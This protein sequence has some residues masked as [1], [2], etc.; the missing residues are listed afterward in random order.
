MKKLYNGKTTNRVHPS[1]SPPA[2]HGHLSSLPAAI[3][4]LAT[5]LSPEEQQVLSYL[6]GNTTT[7]NN[8]KSKQHHHR[9]IKNQQHQPE[10]TCGC[11]LCYK[12]FWSR[13]DSSP[14]RHLIHLIIDAAEQHHQQNMHEEAERTAARGR[15]RRSSSSRRAAGK[16]K[17]AELEE[18]RKEVPPVDSG[19][20][21]DGEG[22]SE[23]MEKEEGG[24]SKSSSVRRLVSFI[25]ERVWGVWN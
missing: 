16:K 17:A 13:W 9:A 3:L 5:A 24:E 4:T 20:V 25:G 10:L 12:S 14:N 11:F 8:N 15:S 19:H 1:P 23:N 22:G 18:D 21:A 2:S 6:L 7:N